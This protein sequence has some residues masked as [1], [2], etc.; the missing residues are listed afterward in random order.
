MPE[1]FNDRF[2]KYAAGRMYAPVL[3]E[4]LDK[5]EQLDQLKLSLEQEQSKQPTPTPQA[6]A[7]KDDGTLKRLMDENMALRNQV[8]EADKNISKLQKKLKKI[9]EE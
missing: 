4:L 9:V 7:P 2:R 1:I 6:S 3:A 8:I 5:A